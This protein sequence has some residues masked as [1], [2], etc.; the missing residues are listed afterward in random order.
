MH[1]SVSLG[2]DEEVRT[3]VD[4]SF[5]VHD[6]AHGSNK[7]RAHTLATGCGASLTGKHTGKSTI[8][9]LYNRGAH[10]PHVYN[11]LQRR[12]C[13]HNH[14]HG[15]ATTQSASHKH[16]CSNAPTQTYRVVHQRLDMSLTNGDLPRTV[17]DSEDAGGHKQV[18][19]FIVATAVTPRH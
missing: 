2:G 10:T 14:K 3:L 6:S 1:A 7:Y 12:L 11:L 17:V 9:E 5:A 4:C 13:I 19:R 18:K 15:K 8:S 16:T